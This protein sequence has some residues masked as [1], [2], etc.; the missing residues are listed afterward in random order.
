MFPSFLRTPAFL[1]LAIGLLSPLL[2]SS[3]IAGVTLIGVTITSTEPDPT[4]ANPIPITFTFDSDVENFDISDIMPTNGSL[5]NLN[6]VSDAIYT[7]DVAPDAAGSVEVAIAQGAG[8]SIGAGDDTAAG[9]FAIEFNAESLVDLRIGKKRN[10]ASHRG[11]DNYTR[12]R[13]VQKKLKKKGTFYLSVENDGNLPEEIRSKAP[14]SSRF[15]SKYRD[16]SNGGANITGALKSGRHTDTYGVGAIRTVQ[17]KVSPKKKSARKSN[18]RSNLLVNAVDDTSVSDRGKVQLQFLPT[19]QDR[20][21]QGT[22]DSLG[23]N[24]IP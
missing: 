5:S 23:G 14:S 6:A 24:A 18:F 21:N 4:T 12:V 13:H 7:V 22:G 11:N 20:G 1:A 10:P 3:A 16:L 8:T 19:A 15:K 2:T 9:M 17:A